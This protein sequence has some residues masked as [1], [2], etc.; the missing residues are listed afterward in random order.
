MQRMQGMWEMLNRIPG[1]ILE[2][3]GKF[4]P[5]NPDLG[6]LFSGLF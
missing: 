5:L 3:S 6:G 2:D 1:S 4:Y